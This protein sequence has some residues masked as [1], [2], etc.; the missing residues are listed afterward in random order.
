M[1]RQ[2]L[3][4]FTDT[5]KASLKKKRSQLACIIAVPA[6]SRE[7]MVEFNFISERTV[8]MTSKFW[9]VI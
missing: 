3:Q 7:V 8:L 2:A 4:C 5:S 1:R 6:G 9:S